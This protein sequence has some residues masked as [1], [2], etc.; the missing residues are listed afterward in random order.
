MAYGP[1]PP[2]PGPG[3]RPGY[4]QQA[5][6][7]QPP[8][9]GPYAPPPVPGPVGGP[10]PR[11]PLGPPTPDEQNWALMAYLAQFLTS[12]VAPLLILLL[13]GRSPYVRRHARQ[14]LN[15]AIGALAVWIVGILLIQAA[16]VLA[17]IP[18]AYTGVVM[19]FL[20]RASIAVNRGQDVTVPAFVAWPLLK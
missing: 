12:A 15:I 18:L 5:P 14:A 19:F 10:A 16:D 9:P 20:V 2:A 6:W 4:G 13:K 17:F 3:P 7:Q 1:P 11:A 8:P